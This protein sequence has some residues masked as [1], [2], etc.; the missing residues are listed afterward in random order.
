MTVPAV[1]AVPART[2][3]GGVAPG[4]ATAAPRPAG[5]HLP[6]PAPGPRHDLDTRTDVHDLVVRF[7]REVVFDA[8]LSPVFDEV[9]QTDW[10]THIPKLV[11]FWCRILLGEPGYDGVVL[12][13][14]RHVHDVE[15]FRIEHFDRWYELW[16]E[17]IDAGW[18]GPVAE[19]AKAHARR[20]G[21]VLAHRL[22]DV[23]WDPSTP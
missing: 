3:G 4:A 18:E 2:A 12:A 10:S 20:V 5:D 7:Y 16:V 17:S 1:P 8:V 23:D 19:H 6:P 21:G 14:H 11:D 13:A 15:A 22:L 9:A